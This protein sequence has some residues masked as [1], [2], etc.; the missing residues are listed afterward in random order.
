MI[1]LESEE[2]LKSYILL[3]IGFIK[4]MRTT[5]RKEVPQ[6][7]LHYSPYLRNR[8]NLFDSV[9]LATLRFDILWHQKRMTL[10]NFVQNI[11]HRVAFSAKNF[12]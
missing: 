12:V 1:W 9:P 2:K 10:Q 11:E 4:E 6:T 5:W 3:Q 8:F 7:F